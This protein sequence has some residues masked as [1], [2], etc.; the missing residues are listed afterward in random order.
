MFFVLLVAFLFVCG[1][2]D[3][4]VSIAKIYPF[5]RSTYEVTVNGQPVRVE[6]LPGLNPN[7][8]PD[9]NPPINNYLNYVRFTHLGEAA[10][11]T[12]SAEAPFSDYTFSPQRL[13]PLDPNVVDGHLTYTIEKS[14]A[15]YRQ[16]GQSCERLALLI[17]GFIVDQA[18]LCFVGLR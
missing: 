9:L 14:G 17:V 13:K 8:N 2:C 11:V 4:A 1:G 5:A 12:I 10:T 3:H 7:P 16:H 18:A 6:R 15:C